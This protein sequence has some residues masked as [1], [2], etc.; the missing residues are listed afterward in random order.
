VMDKIQGSSGLTDDL[1][2]SFSSNLFSSYSP[3]I[4]MQCK[5]ILSLVS[6]KTTVLNDKQLLPIYIQQLFAKQNLKFRL[7]K[8]MPD[9]LNSLTNLVNSTNE[10]NTT[11]TTNRQTYGIQE[12]SSS[13]IIFVILIGLVS[14]ISVIG[15]LCLA[16]VLYSKRYRLIQTDRIVLCLALSENKFGEDFCFYSFI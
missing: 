5:K 15:N 12:R 3:T 6:N 1:S 10:L 13:L 4:V 9:C 14:L 7:P 11:I 2:S 16:K 8:T